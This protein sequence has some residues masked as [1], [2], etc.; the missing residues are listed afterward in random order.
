MATFWI[1]SISILHIS[2]FLIRVHAKGCW[3]SR[4]SRQQRGSRSYETSLR[5]E[6]NG[7]HPHSPDQ[8]LLA[9]SSRTAVR[10]RHACQGFRA[11]PHHRLRHGLHLWRCISRKSKN[12][13]LEWKMNILLKASH[14]TL[15]PFFLHPD[16]NPVLFAPEIITGVPILF[17]SGGLSDYCASK[18][19]AALSHECLRLEL[20]AGGAPIDMTIVYPHGFSGH[21]LFPGIRSL[22]TVRLPPRPL[23]LTPDPENNSPSRYSMCGEKY[24]RRRTTPQIWGLSALG[25]L[26]RPHCSNVFPVQMFFLCFRVSVSSLSRRLGRFHLILFTVC[27][28]DQCQFSLLK[29]PGNF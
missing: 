15:L 8:R 19:A 29:I 27:R 18:A 9:S 26:P 6:R 11:H 14:Y 22:M 25:R 10:P 21:G 5:N 17:P 4:R 24:L 20:R 28:F 3:S 12:I 1:R 16:C 23:S 7:L 13:F 2:R